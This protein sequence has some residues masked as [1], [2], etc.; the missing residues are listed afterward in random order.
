MK[1]ILLGTRFL[2][3]VAV[4]LLTGG[5]T[6]AAAAQS[7]PQDNLPPVQPPPAMDSPAA[8]PAPP[9]APA[10]AP[11]A[12]AAGSNAPLVPLANSESEARAAAASEAAA[13]A[14]RANALNAERSDGLEAATAPPKVAGKALDAPPLPPD[15]QKAAEATELPVVTVRQNGNE[16][17]EEYRK[18]GVLYFVRVQPQEGPPRYYVDNPSNLPPDINQLSAPSGTVQ[19]VYYKLLD[20]H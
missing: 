15:V 14:Q 10:P 19:P 16:R 13:S 5:L 17:I 12:Q 11:A 6:V 7:A 18:K 3:S 8:K 1:R 4:G 20:W 9:A 2:G